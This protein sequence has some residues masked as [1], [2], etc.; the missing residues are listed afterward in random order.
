MRLI[1]IILTAIVLFLSVGKKQI[2]EPKLPEVR[3]SEFDNFN[4]SSYPVKTGVENPPEISAEAF[5]VAEAKSGVILYEKN[6]GEKLRPASTTKLMTALVALDYFNPNDT[7]AVKRLVNNTDESEMGLKVGDRLTV[8]NLLYGLLI[9]SG[10]DA[11]YTLADN[12][13]GGIEQFIYAMNEKA[14]KLHMYNTHFDNPGGMDSNN[15]YTTARDLLALA[16]VT[17][18]DKLISEVIR[19]NWT[20]LTDVTG[21]K[22]Y[23]LQNVNQLLASYP[24]VLGIKTG[25]TLEAGECL[26]AAAKRN[27][28]TIISVILK[29]DDRFRE[30]GELLNWAFDNFQSTPP[31]MLD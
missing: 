7:L 18:D 31:S 17:T 2:L 15:L 20:D 11:A 9:P 8:K 6:A 14:K 30:T 19:T 10:N 13:P 28:I 21:T 29:S 22:H 12:Y 4:L 16:K 26:V 1:I 27:G 5:I 3:E 25:Y 23:Y 24:G